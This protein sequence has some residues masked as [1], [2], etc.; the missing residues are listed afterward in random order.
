MIHVVV[1]LEAGP[2]GLS[3]LRAYEDKVLAWLPEYG[4]RVVTAFRPESAK[5]GSPDEVH[6]LAFESRDALDRFRQDPRH[7]ALKEER[8]AA[9]A[10]THVYISDVLHPY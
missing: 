6:V 3:A 9:I 5:E 7:E 1:L 10:A 2:G 4:G 8:A